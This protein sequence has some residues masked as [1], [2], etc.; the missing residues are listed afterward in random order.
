MHLSCLIHCYKVKRFIQIRQ[1]I[2]CFLAQNVL[3]FLPMIVA[4]TSTWCTT[5]WGGKGFGSPCS[6]S[7]LSHWSPSRASS[8]AVPSWVQSSQFLMS[9]KTGPSMLW[10]L[11]LY[12][13]SLCTSFSF[14]S[15]LR[16]S[17]TS[18]MFVRENHYTKNPINRTGI[19]IILYCYF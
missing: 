10:P 17:V 13:T 12:F 9:R 6:S 4:K 8:R 1:L 14:L 3:F 11:V 15:L 5:T 2:S 7:V 16:I 18:V 19:H